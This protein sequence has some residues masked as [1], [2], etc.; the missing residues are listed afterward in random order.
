[1]R[2]FTL[3]GSSCP[4]RISCRRS[5]TAALHQPDPQQARELR[6]ADRH[7]GGLGRLGH[8]PPPFSR[9]AAAPPS[10]VSSPAPRCIAHRPLFVFHPHWGRRGLHRR[11]SQTEG[12]HR[13]GLH[14]R[15]CLETTP[16]RGVVMGGATLESSWTPEGLQERGCKPT[17]K[18]PNS[19]LGC[20]GRSGGAACSLPHAIRE[21]TLHVVHSG[22]RSPLLQGT[23]K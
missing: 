21:H 7:H 1:M 5:P 18:E 16:Q 4:S 6:D 8:R 20:R 19:P 3:L 9:R 12:L 13:W 14:E 22:R 17:H 23:G 10:P 15:G 11:G 2:G